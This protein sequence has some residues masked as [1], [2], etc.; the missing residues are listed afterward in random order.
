MP[1]FEVLPRPRHVK[2][3][4]RLAFILVAMTLCTSLGF[5]SEKQDS[6]T[7]L[8][9]SNGMVTQYRAYPEAAIK[10]L[11]LSGDAILEPDSSPENWKTLA[12][13]ILNKIQTGRVYDTQRRFNVMAV[14][15]GKQLFVFD[16]LFG[17]DNA[18]TMSQLIRATGAGPRDR[19]EALDLAKL[20]LAL[21]YYRRAD[22]DRIVACPESNST[23]QNGIGFSG[24]IGV[25]D[26]PQVVQDGATYTVNFYAV[27]PSG[28]S[29]IKVCHW[30]LDIGP[31][32]LD[33]R[34][35]AH[36]EEFRQSYS[37]AP[38]QTT[39]TTKK[40]QFSRS[41]MANGFTD[42]GATTDIQTWASSDGPGVARIH[43]YYKSH[44]KAEKRMQNYLLNA[45]AVIEVRPWL[46]SQGKSVGTQALVIRINDSDPGLIAS[47]ISEDAGSVLEISCSSLGNL[48]AA[49]NRD[50][51]DWK[52]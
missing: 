39:Q 15:F 22:P 12:S 52:H 51:P 46:D 20:Y 17:S 37:E 42:D 9:H 26:S 36:H 25:P 29:S 49:L 44:E 38:S 32:N 8:I 1:R 48:L 31:E 50:L 28:M 21:S 40:P 35:S 33:A 18:V 41:I 10:L 27:D 14:T 13:P 30:Q 7:L 24:R 4:P 45:V 11:F 34:L 5:A 19:A 16:A 3:A 47:E 23:E 2:I 43:F 6:V